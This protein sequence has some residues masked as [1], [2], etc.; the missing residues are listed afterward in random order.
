MH[1]NVFQQF[2]Q[3]S[4]NALRVSLVLAIATTFCNVSSSVHVL[5]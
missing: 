2:N 1:R 4:F 5:T 3:W